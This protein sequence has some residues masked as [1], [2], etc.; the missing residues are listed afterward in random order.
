M[1]LLFWNINKNNITDTIKNIS[2]DNEIDILILAESTINPAEILKS[3][4]SVNRSYFFSPVGVYRKI[5]IFTKFNHSFCPIVSESTRQTTRLIKLPQK[6]QFLLC[7]IHA[8]SAVS[9]SQNSRAFE[10]EKISNEIKLIEGKQNTD[11]TILVGDLN[12]NPFDLG[13]ISAPGFHCVNSQ[14]IARKEGRRVQNQYYPYFYNPMWRIFNDSNESGIPGSFYFN[15]SSH[16]LLFWNIFD[17]VLIRPKMI[18]IFNFDNLRFLTD[19]GFHS[20]ITRNNLPN[21]NI[22]DHL[23]LLFSINI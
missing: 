22:S 9:H 23:P 10:A 8:I 20:L 21:K 15:N 7:T 3:L 4:N 14:F 12:M 2:I 5:N 11:M 19:D 17:Q 13:V 18:D 16:D 1:N 6:Q